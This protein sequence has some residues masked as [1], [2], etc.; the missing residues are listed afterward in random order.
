MNYNDLIGIPFDEFGDSKNS[1]NCYNLLRLAFA[2]HGLLVPETNI[3]V[4]ASQVASDKEIEDQRMKY[5]EEIERPVEPCGVLIN[6][7]DSR[8]ANHIGT[9]V[10]RGK[11]L[12]ITMNTNSIIERMD[13]YK[14]RIIGFYKFNPQEE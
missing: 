1:V 9:Y 4:C 3:A 2:K 6:S 5:W 12:H 8:F 14:N 7:S 13:K 11:I 10:G